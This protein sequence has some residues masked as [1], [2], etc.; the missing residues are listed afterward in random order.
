MSSGCCGHHCAAVEDSRGVVWLRG[1]YFLVCLCEV[2]VLAK[3]VVAAGYRLL[4]P[5]AVGLDRFRNGP[6]GGGVLG[7]L[8]LPG[9]LKRVRLEDCSLRW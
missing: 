5:F 2:V 9:R 6:V 3:G 8:G 1:N 7:L 4:E